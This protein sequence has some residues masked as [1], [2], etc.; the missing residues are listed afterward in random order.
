MIVGIVIFIICGISIYWLITLNKLIAVLILVI[1]GVGIPLGIL[2]CA[3]QK[4]NTDYH[5]ILL[6]KVKEQCLEI[7]AQ[8]LNISVYELSD[9]L[10]TYIS[11]N[12]KELEIEEAYN[13]NSFI[14]PATGRVNT[15]K[16]SFKIENFWLDKKKVDWIY[17][18]LCTKYKKSMV[19]EDLTIDKLR[20]Q[21]EQLKL[22]NKELEIKIDLAKPWTC[23]YCGNMN[24]G[25]DM[26]CLKCG[27][28]RTT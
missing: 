8:N 1:C 7:F 20:L 15:K 24:R 14:N 16:E 19:K 3:P 17:N 21:N 11:R 25:D 28:N 12:K 9:A 2:C 26:S 10:K 4:A 13:Y 18:K 5:L 6:N 22:Q 23:Q 27:A